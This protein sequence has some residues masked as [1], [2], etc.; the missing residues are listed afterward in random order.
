ME[1]YRHIGGE[2]HIAGRQADS[3]ACRADRAVYRGS[4]GDY[5]LLAYGNR[6]RV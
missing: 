5:R 6:D 3:R 2:R 4:T 1:E